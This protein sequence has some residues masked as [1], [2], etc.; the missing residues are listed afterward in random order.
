MAK[1]FLQ[2]CYTDESLVEFSVTTGLPKCVNYTIPEDKLA[3]IDNYFQQDVLDTKMNSDVIYPYSDNP[4][5]VNNMGDFIFNQGGKLWEG[6]VDG[7]TTTNFYTALKTGVSAKD[8]F[9]AASTDEETWNNAYA[10][11]LN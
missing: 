5:F 1:K 7:K 8:Y 10:E 11:E 4:I 2:F 6:T 3:L 9:Y